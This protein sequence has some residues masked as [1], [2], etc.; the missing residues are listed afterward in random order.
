M[1]NMI[2]RQCLSLNGF[3]FTLLA[4]GP[5]EG[6]PVILLHGFP[7]FAD[8]W[9][10]LLD[11]LGR[12]GFRAIALNQR[13]YSFGARPTQIEAYDV[14]ELCS[15][16]I[17]L[18]DTLGWRDFHLIGHDWGG[19]IAWWLASHNTNRTRS[20]SVL[21]TAHIDAFLNA[22]ASDPDQ[23]ARSQYIEFF[24]MPDH[25]AE[26]IFLENDGARLR[27]VFQG[28]LPPEQ[29]SANV[30]RLLEPGAL[31]AALNWYR[32]LHLDARIGPIS[33]PTLYIWGDQDMAIGRVAAE[34][35]EQ[36]ISGPYRFEVLPGCS[37]WLQNEAAEAIGS[38]LISHLTEFAHRVT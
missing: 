18:A 2:E 11:V 27:G 25:V 29:V 22:V 16:V 38:L 10:D 36:Y 37:H 13:G 12:A 19:F 32:A 15:D 26:K 28:K 17:A 7:Q 24:K 21:S 6:E 1:G 3:E 35:T 4:D 8:V 33:T 9:T 14:S 34:A 5:E 20:L 30:R 31:T 23:K